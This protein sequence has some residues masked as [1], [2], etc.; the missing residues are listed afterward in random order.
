MP[1]KKHLEELSNLARRLDACLLRP[2]SEDVLPLSFFSQSYDLLKEMMSLLHNMEEAQ[3]ERMKSQLNLHKL[4]ISELV[5][6]ERK[7]VIEKPELKGEPTDR[8]SV[9]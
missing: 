8:K 4:M 1:Y 6:I 5:P 7:P 9:V 3:V 2:D